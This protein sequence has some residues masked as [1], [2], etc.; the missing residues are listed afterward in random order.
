MNPFLRDTALF[1]GA[2]GRRSNAI[3]D[4]KGR[5]EARVAVDRFRGVDGLLVRARQP[6]DLPAH[7][8]EPPVVGISHQA[9]HQKQ[10]NL[11]LYQLP[12]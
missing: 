6:Y 11:L 9:Y 1:S 4:E 7:M 2:G 3:C 10:V 12:I 8:Q 5:S